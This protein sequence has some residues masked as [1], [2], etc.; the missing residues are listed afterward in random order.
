MHFATAIPRRCEPQQ[1]FLLLRPNLFFF[2]QHVLDTYD[3]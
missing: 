3:V 2:S 1:I